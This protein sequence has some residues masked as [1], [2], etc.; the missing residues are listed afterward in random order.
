MTITRGHDHISQGGGDPQHWALSDSS[1]ISTCITEKAQGLLDWLKTF[2][3]FPLTITWGRDH[4]CQEGGSLAL[5]LN[6]SPGIS[7]CTTEKA[8]GLLDQLK[9]FNS[10][11][12]AWGRDHISRRGGDQQHWAL[13]DIPGIPTCIT[14]KAQGLLDRLKT[15]IKKK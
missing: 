7:T 4:T 12:I 1:G 6:D 14:E 2:F 9:T 8:Q 11:T 3:Y 5:A 13:K 15:L 10:M